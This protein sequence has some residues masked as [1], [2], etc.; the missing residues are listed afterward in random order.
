MKLLYQTLNYSRKFSKTFLKPKTK[1]KAKV[2]NK[3][4]KAFI[5]KEGKI[6]IPFFGWI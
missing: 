3:K 2:E 1:T 5:G 4:C 6:F